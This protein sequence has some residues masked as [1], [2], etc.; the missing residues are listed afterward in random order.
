MPTVQTF[1]KA[2]FQYLIRHDRITAPKTCLSHNRQQATKMS[3]QQLYLASQ[4]PRRRELLEQIGQTFRSLSPNVKETVIAG[5]SPKTYV[6]RLAVAKAAAGFVL[7]NDDTAVVLGS[8]TCVVAENTILGKPKNQAH[9]AEMLSQLSGRTHQVHT[10]VALVDHNRQAVKTSTTDVTFRTITDA[11]ANA[12]WQTNEPL[13]KAG[14]YGIQGLAAIFISHISGSYSGV[15]G[16][17]LFETAE[18]LQQFNF[19]SLPS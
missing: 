2:R 6:E 17:P 15:M 11:E 10:A 14:G 19:P 7:A 9:A 13:D 4:S 16:L 12:Y 18:L 3:K 8:D 1:I 5:E